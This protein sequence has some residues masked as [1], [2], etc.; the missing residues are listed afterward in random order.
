MGYPE[1]DKNWKEEMVLLE[2]AWAEKGTPA[3]ELPS[4]NF[5]MIDAWAKPALSDFK[6][7]LIEELKYIATLPI[8]DRHYQVLLPSTL[9]PELDFWPLRVSSSCR[10]PTIWII[11]QRLPK[12]YLLRI[13]ETK[14]SGKGLTSPFVMFLI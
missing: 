7:A 2:G 8:T 6:D 13:R 3:D 14:A 10:R 1:S 9:W 5:K 11:E 12:T 4:L